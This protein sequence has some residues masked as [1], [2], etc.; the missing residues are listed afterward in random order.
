MIEKVISPI[1]EAISRLGRP[2]RRRDE[3]LA[4]QGGEIG[5]STPMQPPIGYKPQPSMVDIVREQIRLAG[6]E[7]ERQGHESFEEADD[8]DVD[9]DIDPASPYEAIFDPP[10]EVSPGASGKAQ[11]PPADGPATPP[12]TPAPAGSPAPAQGG[13][14]TTP[15][16]PTGSA[17]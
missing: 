2:N 4:Q 13:P 16:S 7:A 14:A 3:R 17:V 15:T 10:S 9:D 1:K 8:F 11:E 6:L 12:A 5:S